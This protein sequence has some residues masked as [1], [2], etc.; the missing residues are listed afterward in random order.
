MSKI[1][2]L[3]TIAQ[4]NA[5]AGVTAAI[6]ERVAHQQDGHLWSSGLNEGEIYRTLFLKFRSKEL[7][8]RY[9][10]DTFFRFFM[11][12]SEERVGSSAF[13]WFEQGKIRFGSVITNT[14]ADGANTTVI[15]TARTTPYCLEG[16]VLQTTSGIQMRVEADAVLNGGFEEFTV[17]KLDGTNWAVGELVT[18]QALGYVSTAFGEGTDQPNGR[19]WRPERKSNKLTITKTTSANTGDART[20]RAEVQIG[21][22]T[23]W[24]D[25]NELA[26]AEEHYRN[27]NNNYFWSRPT[28]DAASEMQ[29]EGILPTIEREASANTTWNG[30]VTEAAFQDIARQFDVLNDTD[31]FLV[32]AGTTVYHD[33]AVA[34]QPYHQD[35][36]V[37]YG[38]FGAKKEQLFGLNVKQYSFQDKVFNIKAYKGLNDTDVTGTPPGGTPTATAR[39]YKNYM[40]FINTGN[41]MAG[42]LN[43]MKDEPYI[44]FKYKSLHG[45]DRKLVLGTLRGMTGLTNGRG[46]VSNEMQD[47]R[48]LV[49]SNPVA[50]GLDM[51]RFFMLS[52]I[53]VCTVA[54]D[55]AHGWGAAVA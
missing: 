27:I 19:R 12:Y 10:L 21:G 20:E 11:K 48:S 7:G 5:Q 18:N 8:N 51:D 46:A 9:F 22:R 47:I 23:V 17:K 49:Q 29:G 36:S 50:T 30:A 16:D 31:E 38:Q 35:G 6:D 41:A 40:L 14:P 33:L 42:S 28:P 32:L 4:I 24:V 55:V 37:I 44:R 34:M 53:G 45:V 25:F 43:N 54:A 52:Q 1:T 15:T 13:E 39:D 3:P 2:Q 26:T